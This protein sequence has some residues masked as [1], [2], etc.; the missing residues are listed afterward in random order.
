MLIFGFSLTDEKKL[1]FNGLFKHF[2]MYFIAMD[3]SNKEFIFLKIRN[4]EINI[5]VFIY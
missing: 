3:L 4:N 2:V 1:S 5:S